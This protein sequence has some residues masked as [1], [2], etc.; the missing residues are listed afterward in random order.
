MGI[1]LSG[2]DRVEMLG[3]LK[4]VAT[5]MRLPAHELKA[6]CPSLGVSL[7]GLV[8]QERAE[9]LLQLLSAAK[10]AW[11]PR[12]SPAMAAHFKTL[13]LPCTAEAEDIKRAYRQLALR[14]H[15]DK[16]PGEA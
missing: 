2:I 10:A 8:Q 3:R 1:A 14:Y 11:A 16:N 15:P 7:E 13:E 5:W 9:L 6:E 4:T 12:A